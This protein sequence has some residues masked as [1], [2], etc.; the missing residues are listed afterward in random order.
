MHPRIGV[1]PLYNSEKQTLWINPL[2]FG[3]IEQAGGLPMLLPLTD[4][5]ALWEDCLSSFDGFVFTGGQD[6]DPALY[7]QEKLPECGYQ[8][9]LRDSQEIYMLRR[10]LELNKPVLGICR[11]IQAINVAYGG[12]LYQDI[13]TQAP[14]NVVHRQEMPYEVPH[15]QV[16]LLEN[17]LLRRIVGHQHISVNSM[18]HQ[19]VLEPAPGFIVSAVAPDGLIEAI[20][21]PEKRFLLGVQWHPEHMWQN[22]A[23]G[24]KIWQAFVDACR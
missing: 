3:G 22:Y 9:E 21:C 14:S 8:A 17:T 7:G 18:H 1:L 19:A 16:E 4:S 5:Q 13:P 11:G 10:L 15:H 20:E 12:T 24:K 6:L 2:Y 23:S